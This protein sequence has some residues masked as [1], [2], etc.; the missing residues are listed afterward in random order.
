MRKIE[1]TNVAISLAREFTTMTVSGK[2]LSALLPMG[3]GWRAARAA[4]RQASPAGT[5]KAENIVIYADGGS[6]GNPGPGGYGVVI[7]AGGKRRELA[8]GF[9]L[10][11]NNRME[12]MAAIVG[13]Q[14]L[15]D[16]SAV[17][18]YT[19]SQ[20]LANAMSKGWAKR[21]RANGWMRNHGE[22]ALNPDLWQQLLDLCARHQVKF[23]WVRGHD[24]NHENERS[25]ELAMQAAKGDNLPPDR[26]YES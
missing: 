23:V 11:T 10:T 19:D 2:P 25:H 21:W 8:G 12:I 20:Y 18:I 14:T 9:R 7:L 17:T 16:K 3:D 5:G 13:L 15:K 24:G 1:L 22:P 26:G 4:A 6:I